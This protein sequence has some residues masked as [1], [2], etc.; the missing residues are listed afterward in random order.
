MPAQVKA[1]TGLKLDL[2]TCNDLCI[3][4]LLLV[5]KV[6]VRKDRELAQTRDYL[7]FGQTKRTL[8]TCPSTEEKGRGGAS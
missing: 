5:C 8:A 6:V 1:W 4:T 7:Q 3:N 2:Y